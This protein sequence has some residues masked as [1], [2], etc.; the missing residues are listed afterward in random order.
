MRLYEPCELYDRKDADKERY[1]LSG[2]SEY[3]DVEAEMRE[4][5]LHFLFETSDVIPWEKDPRF[6]VVNL[7]SPKK[8]IEIRLGQWKAKRN[9]VMV[10]N[11]TE[12]ICY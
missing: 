1:N 7:L 8:Q 2:I 12:A 5:V 10:T 9:A 11:G 4:A 3:A 6:P